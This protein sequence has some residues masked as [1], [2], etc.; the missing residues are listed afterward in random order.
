MTKEMTRMFDVSMTD[1]ASDP[2]NDDP[3]GDDAATSDGYGNVS[4][5]RYDGPAVQA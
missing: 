3:Y 2:Y 4:S 5:G 1:P